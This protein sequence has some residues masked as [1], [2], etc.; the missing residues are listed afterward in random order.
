MKRLC[1]ILTVL[2]LLTA[3]TPAPVADEPL[4]LCYGDTSVCI[5]AAVD[6]LLATWD[7]DYTRQVSASCAGV[8]EDMLYTFPSMRLY[9]FA[10]EGG[11]ER[12][13]AVTYTDDASD[14]AD[15][16][17]ARIGATAEA[18]IAA[19]GE[20]DEQSETR[21]IVRD[22]SAVLT[23]TLRDGRVTGMTLAER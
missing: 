23:V 9:T 17:G 12:V 2:V 1:M 19:F 15:T 6:E 16:R 3:C 22:E 20:P 4:A 10:P 11:V 8:G 7:E 13:I 14:E 21:L 5:G 18:V